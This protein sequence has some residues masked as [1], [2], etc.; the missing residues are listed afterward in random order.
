MA[1]YSRSRRSETTCSTGTWSSA[2]A[3]VTVWHRGEPAGV[4]RVEQL[5]RDPLQGI[6]VARQGGLLVADQHV[7]APRRERLRLP[8]VLQDLECRLA[9]DVEALLVHCGLD[10]LDLRVDRTPDEDGGF[11]AIWQGHP[12]LE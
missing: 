5:S 3:L 10:L 1:P 2:A 9:H 11:R 6:G 4:E 12:P 8:L 7:H